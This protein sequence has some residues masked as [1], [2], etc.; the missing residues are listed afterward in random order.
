MKNRLRKFALIFATALLVT[1]IVVGCSREREISGQ[2]FIVTKGRDNVKLGLVGV[3][4]ISE[5]ELRTVA[6][7]VLLAQS[8]ASTLPLRDS[9]FANLPP[10]AVKTDADGQFT[11]RARGKSWLLA[12][13]ER[14]AGS[15]DETYLWVVST[16]G[17]PTKLLLSNDNLLEGLTSLRTF[18]EKVPGVAEAMADVNARTRAE[19]KV[20]AERVEIEARAV[21]EKVAAQARAAA[22]KAAVEAKPAAEKRLAWTGAAMRSSGY[23]EDQIIRTLTQGGIVVAWGA[24]RTGQSD[25]PLRNDQTIVPADLKGV[26]AIAAGGEHTVVVKSDGTVLGW[27][28]NDFG[29]TTIPAGLNGVS[30]IAAGSY[31]TVALKS[32]GTPSAWGNNSHGQTTIPTGLTEVTTIAAGFGHTVALKRNGTVVAWG[33]NSEGQTKVPSRLSEV[34]AI[35]TG[36]YHTVALKRDSTVVAWGDN[37]EGQSEVPVGL[38]GVTAIAAG[39]YH[40][41]ALKRDGTVVTWGRNGASELIVPTGLSGVTAIAAGWYHTV[42]LKRDGT[43]VAWGDNDQGQANVPVG[44]SGVTA[45]AGGGYHTVALRL[46]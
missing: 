34:T 23:E 1:F 18:L 36:W 43:V 45:I 44:L 17:Q 6:A 30:A 42:A 31:H 3:H 27:G 19:A 25:I 16:E 20:V 24:G 39:R 12:R 29:Q 33:D 14:K 4:V 46:K 11:I 9:L 22:K 26:T 41:V 21:A 10:P 32:D 35:A 2:I 5:K 8:A 38:S 37:F 40:T 7:K 15:G 13:A 28:Y